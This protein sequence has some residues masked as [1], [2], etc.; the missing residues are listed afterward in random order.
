M[1]L[2]IGTDARALAQPRRRRAFVDI[3]YTL[4]RQY[5]GLRVLVRNCDYQDII[6]GISDKSL[7]CALVLDREL[8]LRSDIRQKTFAQEEM[9]LVFRSGN[10]HKDGEHADIIMNRGLILVD[11]EPQGLYHIIRILSDLKL[12][13][14]IRFCENLEDMTMT[15]EAGES[16]AILPQSVVEKLDNPNLQVLRLPS[17][18]AKLYLTLLWTKKAENTMFP[19]LLEKLETL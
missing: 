19:E 7:D 15:V 3:L 13:P 18:Y 14:Q 12:E 17:E 9:V 10:A 5:P 4:R 6:K 1:T 16:A 8:E 2:T 11:K